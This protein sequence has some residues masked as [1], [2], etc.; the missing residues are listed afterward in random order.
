MA[1]GVLKA[2]VAVAGVVL[3]VV[4]ASDEDDKMGAGF[5]AHLYSR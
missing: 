3:A 5:R 2:Q 4:L 1:A